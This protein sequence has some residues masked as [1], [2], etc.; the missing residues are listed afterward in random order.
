[1][2]D[3]NLDYL[4]RQWKEEL[5]YYWNRARDEINDYFEMLK[6]TQCIKAKAL[7]EK[8][9]QEI[10]GEFSLD[11]DRLTDPIFIP[12]ILNLLIYIKKN[13]YDVFPYNLISG[14]YNHREHASYIWYNLIPKFEKV[15]PKIIDFKVAHYNSQYNKPKFK[16]PE[17]LFISKDFKKYGL[18][19]YENYLDLINDVAYH[20]K[21]YVILPI[22]LRTLFENIIYDILKT[23]LN[24]KHKKLYFHRGRPAD[25]SILIELL[26]QLS[27]LEFKENIRSNI[28]PNI[29]RIL[30]EIRKM[31][32]LSVHEVL[33]KITNKYADNI[34]D[35]VDL[36]LEALLVSHIQLKDANIEISQENLEKILVKIGQKSKKYAKPTLKKSISV[37]SGK[38]EFLKRLILL[39]EKYDSIKDNERE[40]MESTQELGELFKQLLNIKFKKSGLNIVK[41]NYYEIIFKPSVLVSKFVIRTL[42]KGQRTDS[43]NAYFSNEYPQSK[44]EESKQIVLTD[45]V[46]HLKE[47]MKKFELHSLLDEVNEIEDVLKSFLRLKNFILYL[48]S[49][50]YLNQDDNKVRNDEKVI[51]ELKWISQ[52]EKLL[53]EFFTIFKRKDDPSQYE[54]ILLIQNGKYLIHFRSHCPFKNSLKLEE[55][56]IKSENKV[57]VKA[58]LR[59]MFEDIKKHLREKFNI[60][61]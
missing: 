7:A 19:Q 42:K 8:T 24:D 35:E 9:K 30:K 53:N 2:N 36:V 10:L 43:S 11:K 48:F 25:L 14:E 22:L 1:M 40:E 6:Y 17:K 44:T 41:D 13:N 38:Y 5:G 18:F 34:H 46:N 3:V 23:S 50:G 4:K 31:G 21:F 56:E 29:I 52:N 28:N 27:Q 60:H 59:M 37:I 45:F 61:F 57:E 15:A 26:N 32:N 16:I 54:K 47:R 33:R 55:K 39:L 58:K 49:D 51:S 20:K 12:E